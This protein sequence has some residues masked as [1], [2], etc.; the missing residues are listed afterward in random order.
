MSSFEEIIQKCLSSDNKIR[1]EGEKQIEEKS[2]SNLYLSLTECT[3]I[4]TNDNK[5]NKNHFLFSIQIGLLY[6]HFCI[7]Y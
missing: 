2:L 6:H 7:K 1:K 4:M 5:R 3:N